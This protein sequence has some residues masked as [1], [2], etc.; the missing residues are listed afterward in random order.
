M[1]MVPEDRQLCVI[2]RINTTG[3][4]F[5]LLP[6]FTTRCQRV[7][8][9]DRISWT[10]LRTTINLRGTCGHKSSE[11]FQFPVLEMMKK[12]IQQQSS[13]PWDLVLGGCGRDTKTVTDSHESTKGKCHK[14]SK[15]ESQWVNEEDS[16]K[17]DI[18]WPPGSRRPIYWI[19]GGV[20]PTIISRWYL[21]FFFCTN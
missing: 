7:R 21:F 15:S 1:K 14:V 10:P 17:T 5:L 9:T 4:F 20:W 2:Q 13:Y 12:F 19:G 18:H 6:L 3:D 16:G 8:G 11:S